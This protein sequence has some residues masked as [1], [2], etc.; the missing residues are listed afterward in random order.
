MLRKLLSCILGGLLTGVC[1]AQVLQQDTKPI[2]VNYTSGEV[3]HYVVKWTGSRDI[4]HHEDG[5]PS[6]PL[7]GWFTDTRQCHWS[8]AS[9][10]IRKVYLLNHNG[11]E[12]AQEEFTTPL[13]E[14]FANK[15]S[16][17][18]LT[19]LRPENCGDANARYQSDVA[20]SAKHMADVFPTN[21]AKDYQTVIDTMKG[22][23]KVKSVQPK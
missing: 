6:E 8:I 20:D 22:W 13:V 10:I 11:Q 18:V 4:D 15:G 17:F 7:N 21:V 19:Q 3:E 9:R 1:Y 12:Y 16:D 14:N 5:H 23:P 2:T